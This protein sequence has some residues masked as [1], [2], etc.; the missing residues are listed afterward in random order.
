MG[1][2]YIT[3]PQNFLFFRFSFRYPSLFIKTPSLAASFEIGKFA[4]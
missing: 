4:L 3:P 2:K 1:E